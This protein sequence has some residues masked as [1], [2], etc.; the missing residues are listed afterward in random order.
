MLTNSLILQNLI[1]Q[2]LLDWM[3]SAI[4]KLSWKKNIVIETL[5]CWL[6]QLQNSGIDDQLNSTT[7]RNW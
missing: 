4:L 3:K 5:I 6:T 1:L 2:I 7:G